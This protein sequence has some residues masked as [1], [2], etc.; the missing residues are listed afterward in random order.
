MYSKQP[1]ALLTCF[2]FV[3][4]FFIIGCDNRPSN[5]TLDTPEEN[6]SLTI[7]P[8]KKNTQVLIKVKTELADETVK[9]PTKLNKMIE[10]YSS[11]GDTTKF[12]ETHAKH[13]SRVFEDKWISWNIEPEDEQSGQKVQLI[14]IL[15]KKPGDFQILKKDSILIGK[16]SIKAKINKKVDPEAEDTYWIWFTLTDKNNNTDTLKIDP[17]LR[18]QKETDQ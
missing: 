4:F 5:G 13:I 17:K 6:D 14:N 16:D 8:P 9:D 3:L 11:I 18:M 1:A 10:I 15:N 7:S 12:G 2:A